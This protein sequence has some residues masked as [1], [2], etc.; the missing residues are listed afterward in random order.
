MRL[1][2]ACL[3][4]IITLLSPATDQRTQEGSCRSLDQRVLYTVSI[5]ESSDTA[6]SSN[7]DVVRVYGAV[8]TI[9]CPGW[10]PSAVPGFN[11]KELTSIDLGRSWR[12]EPPL[13]PVPYSSV[14]PGRALIQSPSDPNIQ[15]RYIQDVGLY[16]RSE[17]AG[18]KWL[19]PKFNIQGESRGQFS[20]HF[21]ANEF[22]AAEFHLLTIN[23]KEPKHIY[24]TVVLEPW[25]AMIF[26]EGPLPPIQV[27]GVYHSLNGGENWEK[28]PDAPTGATTLA[29]SA[30]NPSLMY[31][32]GSAGIFRSED[33]GKKWSASGQNDLLV[34][35]PRMEWEEHA[36]SAEE[37][38]GFNFE[39][40]QLVLDPHDPAIIFIVSNKGF[41]RS[42]DGGGSWCLLN[43]G[44]DVLGSSNSLAINPEKSEEI[45][46][47]TSRGV[48]YS[49]DRGNHI[50]KVYPKS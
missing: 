4:L 26:T 16:L 28:F 45:F 2:I 10:S 12:P 18:E 36:E 39:V 41:Y 3:C 38:A 44:L 6:V 30:V 11:Q 14:L 5:P 7:C 42:V 46:L 25:N 40:S 1:P 24:A 9:L 32:G 49:N 17:D 29:I 34:K 37:P 43:L 13:R 8:A 31:A 15:Y 23:P 21:G 48:F 20:I 33:A 50:D 27:P 19:L 35:R 47:G 22:Y